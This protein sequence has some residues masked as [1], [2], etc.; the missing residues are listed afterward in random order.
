MRRTQTPAP[1]RPARRTPL[2]RAPLL[3]LAAAVTVLAALAPTPAEAQPP[4][5]S[6]A[7]PPAAGEL[8]FIERLYEE[9]DSYRAESE[10][11]RFLHYHPQHPRG[12]EVAL[13]RAKLYHRD[14]RYAETERILYSVLDRYP[15]SEAVVPAR[16]LLAFAQVRQGALE[17]AAR[18]LEALRA[19]GVDAP[20]LAT[21]RQAP[22]EAVDPARAVRWSTWLP[23]AGYYLVDE[24]GKANVALGLNLA[25][26]GAAVASWRADLPGAALVFLIAEAA[27][28]TG[29]RE[30][31]RQAAER[32]NAAL[33]RTRTEAWLSRHGEPALLSV[34]LRVRFG[35]G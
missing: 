28:Y 14:G 6:S 17:R 15:R 29:Q 13:L 12:G 34:G 11:L 18:S 1:A 20:S 8:R 5:Q 22:A 9:G 3:R 33:R 24:P 2:A 23:G 31:T 27:L 30:A 32:H 25:F 7:P 4:A 10:A 19:A 21:L 26:L 16:R 35:E